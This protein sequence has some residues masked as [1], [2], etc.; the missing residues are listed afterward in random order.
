MSELRVILDMDR[1]VFR[2]DQFVDDVAQ[3]MEVG[4]GIDTQ[5]F[6]RLA[7]GGGATPNGSGSYHLKLFGLVQDLGLDACQT[8]EYIA[9]TLSGHSYVYDD[10]PPF[11][12]FLATEVRPGTCMLLT[13]GDPRTQQIKYRCAPV[14][15][16][17]P[18]V[19]TLRPKEEYINE[20]F[21]NDCG[22]IIDDKIVR[23]LP[24][25]FRHLWLTRDA[26]PIAGTTYG[27]LTEIQQNWDEIL[28]TLP[29]K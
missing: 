14:L 6:A 12:D 21:F 23:G 9:E 8:E 17:L 27:S 24:L 15:G 26:E 29:A 18:C 1:T 22:V 20:Y 16:R 25:G 28:A 10:V 13:Q 19:D 4:F 5:L 11:L 7:R 3:A 2:T